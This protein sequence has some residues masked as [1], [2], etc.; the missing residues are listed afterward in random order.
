MSI[1]DGKYIVSSSTGLVIKGV[2]KKMNAILTLSRSDLES[3][4]IKKHIEDGFLRFM[5]PKESQPNPEIID[6]SPIEPVS[7][8]PKDIQEQEPQPKKKKPKKDKGE[9]NGGSQDPNT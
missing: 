9:T 7:L 1:K 3:S 8:E 2:F 6:G 4:E 5:G